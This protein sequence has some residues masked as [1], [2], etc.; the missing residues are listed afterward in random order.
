M[1]NYLI[2]EEHWKRVRDY[3][4][5]EIGIKLPKNDTDIKVTLPNGKY[6]VLQWRVENVTMDICLPE[7]LSVTNWFGF[8]MEDAPPVHNQDHVRLAGQLVI[9]FGEEY[10]SPQD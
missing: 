1:G 6:I 5:N 9:D 4:W 8:D 7:N 10:L 2:T 3:K